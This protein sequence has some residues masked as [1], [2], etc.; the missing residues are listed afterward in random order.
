MRLKRYF[1]AGL[2]LLGQL[3]MILIHLLTFW[4]FRPG[5][6]RDKAAL[7]P[8]RFVRP[9]LLRLSGVK[10][11]KRV[12]LNFGDLVLGVTRSPTPVRLGDGVALGPYVTFITSSAP[13][14][15]RLL[16]HPEVQ[17]LIVA[18]GPIDVQ[19]E[20]WIGAGAV[21][22]P[23]VSIGFG[24]IVGAGSVVREDVPPMTVV[25]GVPARVI[26]KLT[27]FSEL[28]QARD[29]DRERTEEV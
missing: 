8:Y 27:D 4:M 15:S 22:F 12:R 24:A 29:A 5:T 20:A 6:L 14:Y 16:Q 25:A 7:T 19:D 26:R 23:G 2:D 3:P 10:V 13:T 9:L 28:E 18:S 11:G 21:I 17:R 1:S